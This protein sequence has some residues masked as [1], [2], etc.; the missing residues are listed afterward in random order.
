M[1]ASGNRLGFDFLFDKYNLRRINGGNKY[2]SMGLHIKDHLSLLEAFVSQLDL[3]KSDMLDVFLTSKLLIGMNSIHYSMTEIISYLNVKGR[4]KDKLFTDL[5][6]KHVDFNSR[7][8]LEKLVRSMMR[9][10]A[11]IDNKDKILETTMNF[12]GEPIIIK[13]GLVVEGPVQGDAMILTELVTDAIVGYMYAKNKDGVNWVVDEFTDAYPE[14]LLEVAKGQLDAIAKLLNRGISL[15]KRVIRNNLILLSEENRVGDLV[16]FVS[17][18][19]KLNARDF[20]N[21]SAA[22]VLLSIIFKMKANC[23]IEFESVNFTPEIILGICAG[24]NIGMANTE[25]KIFDILEEHWIS[26]GKKMFLT[27]V[28]TFY[29]ATKVDIYRKLDGRILHR[30]C[31]TAIT[32][33]IQY[34]KTLY[35]MNELFEQAILEKVPFIVNSLISTDLTFE[36]AIVPLIRFIKEPNKEDGKYLMYERGMVFASSILDGL[37][38]IYSKERIVDGVCKQVGETVGQEFF[39]QFEL[40]KA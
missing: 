12:R 40:N 8:D 6:A 38:L 29:T 31:G 3:G 37:L 5:L 25:L 7:S 32:D 39:D 36:Q 33:P 19:K 26:D 17:I 15:D 2:E 24:T 4:S 16:T 9:N 18:I 35:S 21:D 13:D 10:A 14:R 34:L 28:I 1:I 30:I 23:T 27:M 11:I 22:R 20:L